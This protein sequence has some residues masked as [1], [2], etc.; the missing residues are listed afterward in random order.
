MDTEQ[1]IK[2]IKELRRDM[3]SILQRLKSLSASRERSLSITKLQES[4][5]WLGMDLKRLAGLAPAVVVT[6]EQ[7]AQQ[8]YARYGAVTDFKNFRG[9]P[10]PAWEQLPKT[11]QQAWIAAADVSGPY[12]SSY[13]PGSSVVERTADGLQM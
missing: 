6:P 4:I 11:I 13:N 8:A 5:M 9:E 10:M 1:E 3:D 7:R 2:Q 12:P